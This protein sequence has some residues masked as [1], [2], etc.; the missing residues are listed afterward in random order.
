M[1]NS[2]KSALTFQIISTV[3]SRWSSAQGLHG[4]ASSTHWLHKIPKSVLLRSYLQL[5]P[6]GHT[7]IIRQ[8]LIMTEHWSSGIYFHMSLY[9]NIFGCQPSWKEQWWTC[10][11][12][13]SQGPRV[14][15]CCSSSA[16]RLLV[17]GP[18]VTSHQLRPL[19]GLR[20]AMD[21]SGVVFRIKGSFDA[22]K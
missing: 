10:S 22:K 21:G 6:V 7:E 17:P 14:L 20:V 12:T 3:H 4:V 9:S 2:V 8:E 18:V 19:L 1:G 15:H 11:Q 5:R 16:P 13:L